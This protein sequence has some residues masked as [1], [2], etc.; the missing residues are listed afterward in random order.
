M[1]GHRVEWH[2]EKGYLYGPD[3]Y[4][5]KWRDIVRALDADTATHQPNGDPQ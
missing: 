4:R 5:D 1:T 2:L 3:G